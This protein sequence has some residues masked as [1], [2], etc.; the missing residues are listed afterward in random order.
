M[1]T[2]I[3]VENILLGIAVIIL[4][5]GC[6]TYS[7]TVQRPTD[8]KALMQFTMGITEGG[9]VTV[10]DAEGKSVEGIPEETFFAAENS[11]RYMPK[12]VKSIQ[13]MS[14]ITSHNP[15]C[16]IKVQGRLYKICNQGH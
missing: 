12:G 2:R 5:T 9:E 1:Q 10:F 14:V 13:N 16:Y 15:H 3:N 11:D 7:K 8:T 6:G 4:F